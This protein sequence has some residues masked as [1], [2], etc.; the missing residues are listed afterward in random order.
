MFERAS[1]VRT[2]YCTHTIPPHFLQHEWQPVN[3]LVKALRSKYSDYAVFFYN[4]FSPEVIAMI[5][6]PDAFKPQPFSAVASEFKRPVAGQWKEDSLVIANADDLMEEIGYL[7]RN[8]VSTFKVFDAKQ[9]N[10]A[11]LQKRQRKS[12]ANDDNDDDGSEESGSGS[13]LE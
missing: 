7:S 3:A 5:W 9:P 1:A 4:Q 8:V 13:E 2:E 6:R 10:D 12:P 11:P